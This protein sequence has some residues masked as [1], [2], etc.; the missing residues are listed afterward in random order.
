MKYRK[1]PVV[2]EAFRLGIDSIPDWFMDKVA[3]NDIILHGKSSGFEH[4]DD[5]NADIKT[6][7]G[8]MH[9]NFGDFIIKGIK[10]EIYPCKA[11]IFYTTYEL[12]DRGHLMSKVSEIRD[13]CGDYA[14]DIEYSKDFSFTMFFNSRRNAETVKRCVEADDSIPNAAT[15]V[16]FVEV[17]RCAD[18]K[19]HDEHYPVKRIGEEASIAYECLIDRKGVPA[20]HYCS[21]GERSKNATT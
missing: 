9:A 10:G 15:A 1:K 6:P 16:D 3:S 12:A 5:T 11:D 20:T 7:E 14:I 13:F 18:C 17:V 4:C 2:I 8:V 19:Y 21:Y